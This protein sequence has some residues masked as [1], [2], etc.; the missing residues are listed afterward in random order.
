[1]VIPLSERY[2][3]PD[4][5]QRTN[6]MAAACG[7]ADRVVPIEADELLDHA[8]ESTGL[9]DFELGD[10]DWEQRFRLLVGALGRNDLHVVGRL[11][12]RQ[13]L[14]RC[15]RT[16]LQLAE[17]ARLHPAITSEAIVK[18]L[19]VTGPARSGTTI[20]FELLG[21]DSTLMTP[22]GHL[23][24]H[25]V[26][27]E[28]TTQAGRLTMTSCE[29]ELWSDVQPEFDT[30]HELRSDLPVECIT[31][32]TASFAGNHWTMV[33]ADTGEWLPD[34]DHDLAFHRRML[35]TVQHLEYPEAQRS[36]SWL[37]KTPAHIMILDQL[38]DIYPDASFIQTHR[39]PTRTMPSTVSTAGLI[40]YLR[41][42]EVDLDGLIELV[43]VFFGGAL[44]DVAQRRASGDLPPVF[45]DVHFTDLIAD[46]LDAISRAY[47]A[48]GRTMTDAHRDAVTDYLAA[49]PRDKHGRH[50]YTAR[51]WGFDPEVI[52][53]DLAPYIDHFDIA[54]ET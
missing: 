40:Q 8:Q 5:V 30:V 2:P 22:D 12:T 23:V 1:M 26:T 16:R 28:G 31:L 10:G 45:G 43:P 27:P 38:L 49:R 29:Q 53:R 25:P 44:N 18:P 11:M 33:L 15:L 3:R 21:L 50:A 17:A 7:G 51:E 52:R 14:L 34:V 6:A 48:I 4:W 20:L 32:S 36:K 41:S 35:Q 39:D 24:I 19:I 37:L 13:E 54:S 42:D 9:S 46:P 47:A